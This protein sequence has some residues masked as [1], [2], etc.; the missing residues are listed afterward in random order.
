MFKQ[1]L[2]KIANEVYPETQQINSHNKKLWD[3]FNAEKAKK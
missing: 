2:K 3:K 1:I